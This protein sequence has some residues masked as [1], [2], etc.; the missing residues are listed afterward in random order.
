M[1][2]I[3]TTN[4]QNGAHISV[5][6]TAFDQN[7]RYRGATE[8]Q[9]AVSDI[10]AVVHT[11]YSDMHVGD[12]MTDENYYP[13]RGE[14]KLHNGKRVLVIESPEEIKLCLEK[15]FKEAADPDV[16]NQVQSV[17]QTA[18]NGAPPKKLSN[19]SMQRRLRNPL[20]EWMR[21]KLKL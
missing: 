21:L 4:N 9:V 20:I 2:D 13:G 6:Q 18:F 11:V 5:R 14:L 10:A 15:S 19:P 7:G 17:L 8:R 1:S 12:L 3:E 16:R